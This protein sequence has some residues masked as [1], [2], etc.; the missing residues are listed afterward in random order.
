MNTTVITKTREKVDSKPKKRAPV[1]KL[2]QAKQ[3]KFS[4]LGMGIVL[5]GIVA[6]TFMFSPNASNKS[7]QT[8]NSNFSMSVVGK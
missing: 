2:V 4:W 6:L 7:D 5:A 3:K 8:Q 1:K